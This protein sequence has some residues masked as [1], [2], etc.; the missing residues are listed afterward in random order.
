MQSVIAFLSEPM[1][2]TVLGLI[3]V[4]LAVYFYVK[5][6]QVSRIALQS[7]DIAIVGSSTSA[8]DDQ[9]EIRFGG[10]I[11]Q[12]V[13]KTRVIVWNSGNT[14]IEGD[15]IA[16]SDPLRASVAENNRIL[17]VEL[18]K[19]SRPVNNVRF[20][21]KDNDALVDFDFFDQNDGFVVEIIHSGTRRELKWLGTVRGIPEG[22]S[23]FSSNN[24]IERLVRHLPAKFVRS[25]G[26]AAPVIAVVLG[27][28]LA[29]GGLFNDQINAVSPGLNWPLETKP[30]PN[31]SMVGT[32]T[33][34]ALL[35]LTMLWMR[36]RRFPAALD[37]RTKPSNSRNDSD[38][39][40]PVTLSG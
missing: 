26:L 29:L 8:F 24:P 18:I 10:E 31:W 23:T 39:Q 32:G 21:T 20:T 14:T 22:F 35:P 9:L 7:E 25:L 15:K 11:V 33:V 30:G 2:G 12:R 17:R 13:T 5:A 27:A 28:A 3:G 19:Q 1:V 6:K 37:V 40:S 36:R 38:G 4:G 16:N 34:Y